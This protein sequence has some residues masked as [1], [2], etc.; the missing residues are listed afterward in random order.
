M[1]PRSPQPAAG[2]PAPASPSPKHRRAAELLG[3]A[4][5]SNRLWILF[6]LSERELSAT[7]FCSG[8]GTPSRGMIGR[9]LKLLLLGRLVE[10]RRSG[11]HVFYGLTD[12]GRELIRALGPMMAMSRDA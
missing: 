2:K 11:H 4:G 1:P 9:H 7:L 5:N 10:T 6:L 8:P 12:D 3:Y